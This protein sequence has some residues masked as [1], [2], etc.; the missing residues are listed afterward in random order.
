M[1]GWYAQKHPDEDF[2]ETFAVW[3]TPRS[4]WRTRYRG[5]PALRKL[6]YVDRMARA[7]RDTRPLVRLASTDLTVDEMDMT[8]EEFF[9]RS[10]PAPTPVDVALEH[11]L[12]DLFARRARGS[13]RLEPATDMLRRH[14]ADLINKIEY[15]TGVHRAVVRSLVDGIVET[16]GRLGLRVDPRGEAQTLVEITAYAT[17][18][19]MNFL[20]RGS[21]VPRSRQSSTTTRRTRIGRGTPPDRDRART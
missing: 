6:R 17:T 10:A 2:A 5:W 18:L 12:P 13:R 1:E 3:L 15:W 8:V 16:A 19:T 4:R 20:T 14:R 21:F 11:D 9:R 7:L